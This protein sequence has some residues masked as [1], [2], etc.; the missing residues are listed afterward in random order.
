VQR[1]TTGSVAA[2]IAEAWLMGTGLREL[3]DP[4]A[5]YR[6]VAG[7]EVQRF[8]ADSFEATRRVEG[9]VRGA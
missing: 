3:S 7:A 8:A 1:Q 4:A 9:I 6:A 5:G 2:E